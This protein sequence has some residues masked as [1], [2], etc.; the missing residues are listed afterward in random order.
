MRRVHGRV[1]F[2]DLHGILVSV[3][4]IGAR[5]G[6]GGWFC[7][8]SV[9]GVHLQ[10]CNSACVLWTS[11]DLPICIPFLSPF[12][13]LPLSLVFFLLHALFLHTC[14]CTSWCFCSC[15]CLPQNLKRHHNSNRT[16]LN[17]RTTSKSF[18][19]FC[20]CQKSTMYATTHWQ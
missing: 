13:S 2:V 6:C 12:H 5:M 7:L 17:L 10:L 14:F 15:A 1:R 8:C 20:L 18:G 11:S 16:E 3:G 4:L 19:C 9:T